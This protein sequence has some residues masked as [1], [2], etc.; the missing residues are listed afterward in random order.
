MEA[1]NKTKFGTNVAWGMRVMPER[2]IHA[3]RRENAWYHTQRWKHIATY[4]VHC[5]EGAW[6]MTSVLVTAL[7]NQPE[8][9]A[10]DLGDDQS[11]YLLLS[12]L[13]DTM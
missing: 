9:F 3:Q 7:C 8:A 11:R 13:S 1:A 6:D 2:R 10:S 12:H 5:S 4:D